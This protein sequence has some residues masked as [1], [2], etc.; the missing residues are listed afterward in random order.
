MEAAAIDV[1]VGYGKVNFSKA[2]CTVMALSLE[3]PFETKLVSKVYKRSGFTQQQVG[4][5]DIEGT[6]YT[7]RV[8]IPENK[9][10]IIQMSRNAYGRRFADGAVILR[11]RNN[12]A[13][14]SVSAKLPHDSQRSRL[15]DHNFHAF[16]G[17]ADILSA[18]EATNLYGIVFR[19]NWIN[20]YMDLE[21]ISECFDI[22]E[23]SP[24]IEAAPVV[25]VIT[26]TQ[27]N[28]VAITTPS[29]QRRIK[30]RKP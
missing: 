29:R 15:Q 17:R 25:E 13:L 18:T 12:A 1:Q 10:I 22:A 9:L 16:M 6:L 4:V 30:L 14:I 7:E 27:G 11:V 24:E 2:S 5:T 28:K 23:L 8:S 3:P 26:T 19:N 20:Q 21:E